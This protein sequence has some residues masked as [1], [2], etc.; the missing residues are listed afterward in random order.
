MNSGIVYG[1]YR[2]GHLVY[3]GKSVNY[4]TPEY[5][6][7]HRHTA[8][9]GGGLA[10]DQELRRDENAFTLSIIHQM[11]GEDRHAIRREVTRLEAEIIKIGQPKYNRAMTQHA[12]EHATWPAW[13]DELRLMFAKGISV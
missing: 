7:R 10:I 5:V 13:V 9:M 2:S 3:V 8:H 6:L 12:G 1:Y 4:G 11:T